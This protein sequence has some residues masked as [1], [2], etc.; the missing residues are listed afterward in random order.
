MKKKKNKKSQVTFFIILGIMILFIFVVLFTYISS[1]SDINIFKKSPVGIYVEE[2]LFLT[3]SRALTLLG[4]QG[5]YINPNPYYNFS[6]ISIDIAY[7]EGT[8]SLVT[9]DEFKDELKFFIDNY[10]NDCLNDFDH[11][12][13]LGYNF[14]VGE[15]NSKIIITNKNIIVDLNYKI[16]YYLDDNTKKYRIEDFRTTV[17]IR[18][19]KILDAGNEIIEINKN[20]NGYINMTHLTELDFNVDV[21]TEDNVHIYVIEDEKSIIFFNPYK[22][23]FVFVN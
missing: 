4:I 13:N 3:T 7:N 2:C 17:P 1:F 5:G 15:P 20:N 12:V 16:S 23:F 10:L 21:I 19:N 11:F 18:I 14:E 8:N 9:N 6:N 22:F